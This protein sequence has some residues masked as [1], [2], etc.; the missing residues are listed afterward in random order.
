MYMYVCM[1]TC[2]HYTQASVKSVPGQLAR[3]SSSLNQSKRDLSHVRGE[4]SQMGIMNDQ[5]A[6][7]GNSSSSVFWCNSNQNHVVEVDTVIHFEK[8]LD[9]FSEVLAECRI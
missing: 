9:K 5:Q 3:R 4:L 2:K 6:A 8:Q 7:I 1:Y